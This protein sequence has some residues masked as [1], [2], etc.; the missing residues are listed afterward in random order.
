M[1]HWGFRSFSTLTVLFFFYRTMCHPHDDL[2]KGVGSCGVYQVC[3]RIDRGGLRCGFGL[4]LYRVPGIPML[5]LMGCVLCVPGP[6]CVLNRSFPALGLAF[7]S[8][9]LCSRYRC[10]LSIMGYLYTLDCQV[11][12]I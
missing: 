1:A 4:F 8:P 9:A 6:S 10:Y 2:C 12:R 7:N 11:K 5:C 3:V